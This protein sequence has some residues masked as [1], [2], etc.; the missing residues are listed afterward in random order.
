MS[1]GSEFWAMKKFDTCDGVE[2]ST[3]EYEFCFKKCTRV[4]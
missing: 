3:F 4:P 2:Y 1:Y